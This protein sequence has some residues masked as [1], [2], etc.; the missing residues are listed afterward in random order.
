MKTTIPAIVLA[1]ATLPVVALAQS[2]A[3][4][5]AGKVAM[6]DISRAVL[7]TAEGKS[8]LEALNKKFEP[9]RTGLVKQGTDLQTLQQQLADSGAKLTDDARADLVKSIEHK[10][11]D[12][13]H[14]AEDTQTDYNRERAEIIGRLLKKMAPISDKYGRDNGYTMIF[15]AQF[16]P[17]GP[18]LWASGTSAD[19]TGA[20]V[21]AYDAQPPAAAPATPAVSQSSGAAPAGSVKP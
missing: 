7:S 13:Q 2:P 14:A 9:L 16:W 10:Q 4:S 1:A 8:D 6:I 17:T 11:L 12:L 20:V 5:P 18:V 15:D 19:V 21:S 3:P